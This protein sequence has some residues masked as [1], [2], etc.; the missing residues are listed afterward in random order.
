MKSM[1][2]ATSSV[3]ISAWTKD[4]SSAPVDASKANYTFTLPDR[5]PCLGRTALQRVLDLR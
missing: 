1:D 2:F 3:S 5:R 4:A